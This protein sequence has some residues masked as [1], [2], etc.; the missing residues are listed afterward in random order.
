VGGYADRPRSEKGDGDGF[1]GV[2]V[3][4]TRGGRGEG[5]DGARTARYIPERG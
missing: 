4:G 3:A 5:V 2:R 1:E